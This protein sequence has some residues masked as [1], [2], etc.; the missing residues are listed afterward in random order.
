MSLTQERILYSCRDERGENRGANWSFKSLQ[1][2]SFISCIIMSNLI[3]QLMKVP[4]LTV[5][6]LVPTS[7]SGNTH[8]ISVAMLKSFSDWSHPLLSLFS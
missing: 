2:L 6:V 1:W 7:V 4:V 8:I 5:Y 3:L